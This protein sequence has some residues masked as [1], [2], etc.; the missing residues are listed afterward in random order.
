MATFIK[1]GIWSKRKGIPKINN[2]ELNLD[3]FVESKVPTPPY[4]VYTALLTQS[5]GDDPIDVDTGL[6]TVGV[7]YYIANESIGMDF[8]NVGAPNNNI[9][10][11]FVATGTTPN[12]WGESEGLIGILQYNTA[13]PVVTVLENTIGDIW[14]TYNNVGSYYVMSDALFIGDKTTCITSQSAY[15]DT[16]ATFIYRDGENEI[17]IETVGFYSEVPAD[18][19]LARTMLEIRVYN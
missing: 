14:F 10:T 12:N 18:D 9:L 13:A 15:E 7:T 17:I 11:F 3:Q 8:T 5:G 19:I 4:K 2:G 6:L 16:G 1:G